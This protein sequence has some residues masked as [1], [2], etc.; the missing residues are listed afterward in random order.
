MV[1]NSVVLAVYLLFSVACF[2][3]VHE[4]CARELSARSDLAD[5]DKI[6][7]TPCRILAEQGNALELPRTRFVSWK[8]FLAELGE[9]PEDAPEA[10]P[11]PPG[12]FADLKVPV[13]S[14]S[15]R[16]EIETYL[17]QSGEVV[18][19]GLSEGE[20]AGQKAERESER[21]K[22]VSDSGYGKMKRDPLLLELLY[23]SQG[24]HMGDGVR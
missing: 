9:T 11:I 1:R 22:K 23:C 7:T 10:S 12:F 20:A 8:D 21:R 14:L 6:I 4:H 18:A 24:C 19:G 13:V 15:G 5:G 2:L 3:T 16:E 17:G